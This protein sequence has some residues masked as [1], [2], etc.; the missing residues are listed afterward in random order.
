[1]PEEVKEGVVQT[2]PDTPKTVTVNTGNVESLHLQLLAQIRDELA[3]IGK[4]LNK[5][6]D[7]N[8]QPG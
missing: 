1:M 6:E 4:A 2:A 3:R 7:D 8:K 5:D